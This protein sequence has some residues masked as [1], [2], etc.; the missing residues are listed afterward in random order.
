MTDALEFARSLVSVPSIS[1]DSNGPV[2]DVVERHLRSLGF[3]IERQQFLDPHGVSKV[4]IIGR[5][6]PGSGGLAY[7]AHTDVVPADSWTV[8]GHG[9]FEPTVRDGRLYGR[10]SCDMKGS[11]AC[12]LAAAGR[13]SVESM[14]SPLYVVCTAD[15]EVGFHGAR[16]VAE[17]STMYREMV[18][19]QS[20]AVIGEPTELNVVYAHKGIYGFRVISHGRAAH[21]STRDGVNAN[22][23]MIPFLMEMKQIHDETLSDPAWSNP[24]FDPPW[25]S[26]N[27]G[28]NDHHCAVNITPPESVCTVYFR[29]MPGHDGD[30]LV[31]RARRAA[32]QNGLEFRLECRGLPLYGD[33]NSSFVRDALKIAGQSAARTVSY[34]TDG[35]CFTELKQI[36]VLGP[37]SIQ[38]AHTDDEWIDLDQLVA[39]TNVYEAMIRR[40]CLS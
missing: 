10:G 35:V 40:W 38:Q 36:L 2:S 26:W 37:G 3:L 6:G 19:S 12:M 23:A 18:A 34:G 30:V 24:E 22:V 11:L 27:I 31:E 28:I 15:E 8:T 5:K 33:P 39:G 17:S 1:R 32:D 21:S 20:R 13:C 7:F 14:H 4:N 9:P 25:I 16:Q 29:P